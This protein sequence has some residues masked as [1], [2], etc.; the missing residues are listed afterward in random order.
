MPRHL[1]LAELREGLP[2]IL[3]SPK[4]NGTLAG[5]VIRPEK[6]VRRELDSCELSLAHGAHGDRWAKG[7]WKTAEDGSPQP[8]VQVRIMNARCIALVAQE[9]GNW[10]PAGDSP[11]IDLDLINRTGDQ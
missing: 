6:G 2:E 3:R 11:F 7:C 4:D 1:T 10:A 9:R 5:I 8:D